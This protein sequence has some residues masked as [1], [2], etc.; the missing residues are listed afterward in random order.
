MSSNDKQT[1]R[2]EVPGVQGALLSHFIQ[3]VD[4]SS[5]LADGATDLP[6]A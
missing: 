5:T 3:P 6:Q 1:P 2:W 4:T